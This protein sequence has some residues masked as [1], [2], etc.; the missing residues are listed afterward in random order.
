MEFRI[1]IAS[2]LF[3]FGSGLFV[4]EAIAQLIQQISVTALIHLLEGSL[5]LVG[6]YFFIPVPKHKHK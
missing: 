1:R 3:V 2:W 5:F 4:M 6:S